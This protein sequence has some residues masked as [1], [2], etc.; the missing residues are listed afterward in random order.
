MICYRVVSAPEQS[1]PLGG[2]IEHQDH[3]SDKRRTWAALAFLLALTI[4]LYWPLTISRDYT[5]LENPDQALQ[6]RPWLDFQAREI[7]AGR[8]PL[9]DPYLWGGQSLIGQVQPG[10]VNP[11]NW[12]LFALPLRDGH[13]PTSTLHW[14]WVLIHWLAAIFAFCLRSEE[15]TS[16]LQSLRHL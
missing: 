5:W 4:G 12:I 1:D 10:V 7:H 15:H 2:P 11:I 6:V 14:Y 9:W 8:L 3:R 13:I 16:E